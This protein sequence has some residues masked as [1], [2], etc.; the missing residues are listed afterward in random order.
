MNINKKI[1]TILIIFL[2]CVLCAADDPYC[3]YK[4]KAN[5]QCPEPQPAPNCNQ[6]TKVKCL[7][8]ANSPTRYKCNTGTASS[9]VEAAPTDTC[10]PDSLQNQ[11]GAAEGAYC[12]WDDDLKHCTEVGE[13][14]LGNCNS[15]CNL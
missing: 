1:T 6:S 14:T 11:C 12:Q 7:A 2:S 8:S 15:P 5:I 4:C 10:Q 13:C 9:C 3:G